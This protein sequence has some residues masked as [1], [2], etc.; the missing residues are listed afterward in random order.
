M[1]WDFTPPKKSNLSDHDVFSLSN[2]LEGKNIALMICGGV[3]SMKAPLLARELRRH[4]AKIT[5]YAS[6]EALKYAAADSLEW[7]SDRPIITGLTPR[8]EHLNSK[9][10]FDLFLIAPATYNTINKIASG[11]ADSLIPTTMAAVIGN[12]E[13]GNV[14]ALIAP[15]MHGDMHN[16]ILTEN[17]K[18]LSQL[19]VQFIKPRQ[20][21]GKNNLPNIDTIVSECI[22]VLSQSKLKGKSIFV[23]GGNT[24]V[25]IDSIRRIT[26][27]FT[28]KLGMEL[29]KELH[30]RGANVHYLLSGSKIQVPTYLNVNRVSS[31]E[32]YKDYCVNW[33]KN[34]NPEFSILSAAVADYQPKVV[35]EGK[36][37]SQGE[38][39][40]ID[41]ISTDKVVDLI[42]DCSPHSKIVSF[43][44][45]ENLSH[46]ELMDIA[47]QRIQKGHHAVVAN[48]GEDKGPEGQQVAYFV[49][50][51]GQVKA[52]G[53]SKIAEMIC[54]HLEKEI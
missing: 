13:R 21:F 44:Y 7:S 26:N 33:V 16:S 37:K 8:A 1:T 31:Y 20:D 42:Y 34:H 46:T 11:T 27:I 5:I 48:R 19:G 30:L 10:T 3:A 22:R 38:L 6:S 50:A 41:L 23:T 29:S 18:K 2:H 32:D 15:T 45:E 36:T 24:P 25:A 54:D 52:T 4:G 51:K 35:L 39:R 43:K 14:Q 9:E 40:S 17:M 28:G 47:Q 53:K 12:V 49:W